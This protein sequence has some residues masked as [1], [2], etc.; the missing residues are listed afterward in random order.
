VR[1]KE[2]LP[3]RV[4][5]LRALFVTTSLAA[6]KP[7]SWVR[8][9]TS[10]RTIAM[11][12]RYRRQARLFAELHLGELLPL[13]AAIPELRPAAGVTGGSGDDGGCRA[14]G[15]PPADAEPNSAEVHS[16]VAKTS[17]ETAIQD[18]PIPKSRV[19]DP[20]IGVRIPA[21]EQGVTNL[22]LRR[23]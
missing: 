1:T 3:V 11:L 16:A 15:R 10:H 8:D 9:R 6:G 21:P 12:D 18:T 13:D 14:T 4:H 22:S 19:L 17:D 23:P 5:D 7:E 20:L 2:S